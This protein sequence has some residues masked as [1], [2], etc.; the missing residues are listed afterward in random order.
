MIMM[1]NLQRR[2]RK[3]ELSLHCD[4]CGDSRIWGVLWFGIAFHLVD[5][6]PNE[7]PF[8]AFARAVG[9]ADASELGKAMAD[10]YWGLNDR[11]RAAEKN[12]L[13]NLA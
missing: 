10:D 1:G 12:C 11:F 8:S 4:E 5:L 6:T 9:Y 2:L 3:L 13:Q 7:K